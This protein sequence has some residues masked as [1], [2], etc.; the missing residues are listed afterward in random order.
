MDQELIKNFIQY[1]NFIFYNPIA[2]SQVANNGYEIETFSRKYLIN[3]KYNY[4]Q[5][6]LTHE[7][8]KIYCLIH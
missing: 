4:L 8:K 3:L 7:Q 1:R 6:N 5:K 2:F